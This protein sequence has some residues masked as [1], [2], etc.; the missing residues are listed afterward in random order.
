MGLDLQNLLER[1]IDKYKIKDQTFIAGL[2]LDTYHIDV[3]YLADLME[4]VKLRE[5]LDYIEDAAQCAR[6]FKRLGELKAKHG[7]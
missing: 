6:V 5:D 4:L 3:D 7:L 2:A 1:Y